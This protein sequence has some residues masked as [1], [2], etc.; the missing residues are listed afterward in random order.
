VVREARDGA[1]F[2]AIRIIPSRA[3]VATASEEL[4][5]LADILADPRPVTAHGVAQAWILLTDGTGPLY[6]SSSSGSLREC[7]AAAAQAL[8]LQ[9]A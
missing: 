1:A 5:A 3:R 4:T 6:N 9:N 2:S 8:R 7:A